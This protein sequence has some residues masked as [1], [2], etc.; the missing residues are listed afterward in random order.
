[1]FVR[2][3]VRSLS[4]RAR[5][6]PRRRGLKKSAEHGAADCVR[7]TQRTTH[8]RH[9]LAGCARTRPHVLANLYAR[10]LGPAYCSLSAAARRACSATSERTSERAHSAD[11][12][13]CE[14]KRMRVKF[15][16]SP[17]SRALLAG[18]GPGDECPRLLRPCGRFRAGEFSRPARQSSP[19]NKLQQVYE[20]EAAVVVQWEEEEALEKDV[21]GGR[22]PESERGPSSSAAARLIGPALARSPELRVGSWRRPI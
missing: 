7:P 4:R 15:T 18:V 2:A 3:K 9:S 11:E 16:R 14:R 22:V 19:A 8:L 20:A 21:T 10:R 5:K 17:W 6:I 12:R 13:T 1:M